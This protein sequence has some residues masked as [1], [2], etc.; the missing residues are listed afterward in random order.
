M[1][2]P[3]TPLD[4][5]VVDPPVEGATVPA[6]EPG[7]YV[8][9]NGNV[10]NGENIAAPSNLPAGAVVDEAGMAH[11]VAEEGAYTHGLGNPN[12]ASA[13]A[14]T[15]FN[16]RLA[17]NDFGQ[18]VSPPRS[19]SFEVCWTSLGLM[20]WVNGRVHCAPNP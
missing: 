8:D 14:V 18:P 20:I 19:E 3:L 6:S 16:A 15:A 13:E 9:A 5:P 1:S 17:F 7:T 10:Q 2:E 12:A 11:P 4:P